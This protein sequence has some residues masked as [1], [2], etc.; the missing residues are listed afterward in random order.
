M[1]PSR[2]GEFHGASLLYFGFAA[3]EITS[4]VRICPFPHCPALK[5]LVQMAITVVRAK[6]GTLI[7][8]HGC[9][10]LGS[11]PKCFSAVTRWGGVAGT[12]GTMTYRSVS[13]R[14]Q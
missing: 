6:V 9:G 1:E 12:P 4:C 3:R 13:P 11:A 5:V 2:R 7:F 14:L 10:L 8:C